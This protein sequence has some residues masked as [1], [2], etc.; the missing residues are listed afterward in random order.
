M[1]SSRPRRGL[2]LVIS[3]PSGVGKTSLSRR[4]V[5]DH[6]DL[7]LSISQT[8]RSPRPGERQMVVL[9]EHRLGETAAVVHPAA[10]AHSILL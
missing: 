8:T 10:G 6:A 4:L 2:M 3:G 9:D 5:A 1:S 7:D